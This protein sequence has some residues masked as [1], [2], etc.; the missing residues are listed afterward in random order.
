MRR[1]RKPAAPP[2][3]PIIFTRADPAALAA[4]ERLEPARAKPDYEM[5]DDVADY[6]Q[7]T[8]TADALHKAD[9]LAL[10]V[11]NDGSTY[12]QRL[13]A[14]RAMQLTNTG[15]MATSYA[16]AAFTQAL[17]FCLRESTRPTY[18]GMVFSLP[19]LHDAAQQVVDYM[20]SHVKETDGG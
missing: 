19:V 17:N 9:I 18:E 13:S 4:N 14:A 7:R 5:A 6:A 16:V 15:P 3:A 1:V 10:A 20:Q 11:I 2:P 8:R 12:P